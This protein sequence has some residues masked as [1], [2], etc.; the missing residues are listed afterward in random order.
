MPP[1]FAELRSL[2]TEGLQRLLDRQYPMYLTS[3]RN[4]SSHFLTAFQQFAKGTGESKDAQDARAF[5]GAFHTGVEPPRLSNG[6][7]RT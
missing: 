5:A 3:A 7:G 6:I 2:W 4:Q 1:E